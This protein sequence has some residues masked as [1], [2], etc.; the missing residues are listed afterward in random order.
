[1]TTVNKLLAC[2]LGLALVLSLAACESEFAPDRTRPAATRAVQNPAN[3]NDALGEE[4]AGTAEGVPLVAVDFPNHEGQNPRVR[5][6]AD[7]VHDTLNPPA[8]QPNVTTPGEPQNPA[9]RILVNPLTGES[10]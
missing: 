1:M 7:V 8:T 5:T 2:N 10:Q 3:H 4:M 9:N 6:I